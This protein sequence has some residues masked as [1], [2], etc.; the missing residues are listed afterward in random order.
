VGAVLETELA[1]DLKEPVLNNTML[2][3]FTLHKENLEK[4]V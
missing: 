1:T 4:R 3:P 2:I